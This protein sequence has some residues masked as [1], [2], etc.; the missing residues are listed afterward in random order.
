MT[1]K[2]CYRILGVAS[3]ANT[4]DV[5]HAYRRRAFELHPDLNP[6][7]VD[8]S[9]QFQLL[10]EA[11]VILVR[12]LSDKE[13]KSST[14]GARVKKERA[15]KPEGAE[16]KSGQSAPGAPG[17]DAADGTAGRQAEQTGP[18]PHESESAAGA[19]T[20]A[21]SAAS[22]AS[23][24]TGSS[25]SQSD[26]SETAETRKR[27][28]ADS[29]YSQQEDVLRDILNDQFARRVFEDIYSEV[30]KQQTEREDTN[31]P[32]KAALPIPPK[33]RKLNLEWGDKILNLDF[34]GGLSGM[35]G[36][37]LR[38]QIDDT[39]TVQLPKGKLFPG[40][41]VRL[42]IRQG[43]KN[44]LHVVEV[45]LPQDFK[46]GKAIRLKGMGRKVGRWTGDLYLTIEAQQ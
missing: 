45:I 9:R 21:S 11:Y 42:Q 3:T 8:A 43:F 22:S 32:G 24:P 18:K 35:V 7:L 5:K 14:A 15:A 13:A 38:K 36:N 12:V 46:I 37:W 1:I 39:L 25:G 17:S 34:T 27:R 44:E 23:G 10:N 16:P 6:N 41:R 20:G 2:E 4:E 19:S 31:K 29:V 33:T 40:A 30:N 26:E 28:M